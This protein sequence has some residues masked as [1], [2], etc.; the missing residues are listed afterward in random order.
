MPSRRRRRQSTLRRAWPRLPDTLSIAAIDL[1][2]WTG[3]IRSLRRTERAARLELAERELE[4]VAG[5]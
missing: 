5:A 1:L 2:R 3:S 4:F